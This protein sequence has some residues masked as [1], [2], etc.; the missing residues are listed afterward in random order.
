MEKLWNSFTGKSETPPTSSTQKSPRKGKPAP[1]PAAAKDEEKPPKTDKGSAPPPPK[2]G[3]DPISRFYSSLTS[4]RNE[5]VL[6]ERDIGALGG[7]ALKVSGSD[8]AWADFL[9]QEETEFLRLEEFLTRVEI[10][11][12]KLVAPNADPYA[13]GNRKA[14]IDRAE[15][16]IQCVKLIKK[17]ALKQAEVILIGQVQQQQ[18]AAQ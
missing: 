10:N 1:S 5:I 13:R 4:V 9:Q 17:R 6:L 8:A 14:L 16:L 11:A 18:Q 3:Y 12:D 7:R 2:G 15:Q